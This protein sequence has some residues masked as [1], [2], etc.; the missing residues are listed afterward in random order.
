MNRSKAIL[1]SLRLANSLLW[2]R[3]SSTRP[4]CTR[5][6]H[7]SLLSSF[8]PS[9]HSCTSHFLINT[10]NQR[11]CFSTQAKS[12]V[13]LVIAYDW[14]D[15]LENKLEELNKKL[16]HETVIYILKKLDKDPPKAYNF[17]NW[18]CEE[19][20]FRPSSSVYSMMLR[21]LV[22]KESL[23]HFW[24]TIRKMKEE[25]CYID[26]ETYLSILGVLKKAKMGTDVAALNHFYDRMIEENAMDGVARNVVKVILG[27]EWGKK[28]EK[29]L[30][31]MKI[32]V[33]D[34]LVIRILKELRNY[35][36]KVVRFFRW[37]GECSGY[38]HNTITYNATLRVLTRHDSI[39]E[40]WSVFEVMKKAGHE[41]D[42]DT[43]IKVSRQ[44][45][46]CRMM[47]DAVKLFELM[48]D[49]P[50]K[51]SIQDCNLLLK[52]ISSSDSPN[53]DLVFRVAKKY[54]S[55]GNFL[56]KAMYDGIHRS[57]TSVGKFDEAEK[58]MKVMKNAGYEPD[59]ITYSQ[60]V[61][62]LC[63]ARRLDEASE[64]LDEMEA[65]GCVPDIKTWTILIQGHCAANEV[66]KALMCFAK[67]M[68]TNCDADADLLDVLVK[69]FLRQNRVTGAYELL[70]G[71]VEKARL[72]PWQ[73]TY[74][75][76]IEKLLGVSKLEEAMGLLRLMKKQN[77]P[78]Y[79]EP[80][81]QY[82]SKF[83]SLQDALEFLKVLS[84]KEYPSSSA[85]LHV[86]QSFFNEGRHSEAKDL[87]Y[88]CPHHIRN[89]SKISA[90]FGSAKR[91]KATVP[92]GKESTQV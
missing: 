76:L 73:A 56:S 47:E 57:L 11:L 67:L 3:L 16:T 46:K 31:E 24:I 77:Y 91:G 80:F 28:V 2:T 15:D 42:I 38:E 64:L 33:S 58:I 70:M 20:G 40:F 88:K 55:M 71:L 6:T 92:S 17:F 59:N 87:L 53:L 54:E 10:H 50:Y 81:I 8:T 39:E 22:N 7:F 23:K 36:L 82:I 83:G 79:P 43:Y 63:K 90:L 18:V 14:S 51:P 26:E 35:P 29:E 78:P 49:C 75:T 34:N 52:S 89:D 37:V 84:V 9:Y 12:I 21:V 1:A 25:K 69:G 65:N 61:F 74:K 30:E 4:I 48:M 41:M 19:N 85:Y 44:L 32:E 86:F 27:G 62:G 72:R 66:D 68:E 5:V 13:D 60:L 45:Q